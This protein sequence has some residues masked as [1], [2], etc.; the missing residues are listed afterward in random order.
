VSGSFLFLAKGVAPPPGYTLVGSV[1]LH[2]NDETDHA[3]DHTHDDSDP[4]WINLY[5]KN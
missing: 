1:R 3:H 5:I 2:F 4:R